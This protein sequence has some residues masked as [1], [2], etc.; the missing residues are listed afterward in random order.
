MGGFYSH[1]RS[2][3][4]RHPISATTAKQAA[5]LPMTAGR[6]ALNQVVLNRVCMPGLQGPCFTCL[7]KASLCA[8]PET[9]VVGWLLA[10]HC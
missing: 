4:T 8:G 7:H 6:D 3:W 2:Q 5:W 10:E 1:L 9:F